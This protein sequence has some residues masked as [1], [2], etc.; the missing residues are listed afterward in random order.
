MSLHHEFYVSRTDYQTMTLKTVLGQCKSG[1][2]THRGLYE[3]WRA[4]SSHPSASVFPTIQRPEQKGVAHEPQFV[5]K[6]DLS[7][8]C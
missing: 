3:K 8:G 2:A 6:S 5:I 4:R 7:T 1:Y